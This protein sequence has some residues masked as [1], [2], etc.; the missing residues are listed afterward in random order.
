M[1]A[2]GVIETFNGHVQLRLGCPQRS[3]A[4]WRVSDIADAL[5]RFSKLIN[6]AI[7]TSPLGQPGWANEGGS[8]RQS[9][10]TSRTLR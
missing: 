6:V 10:R 2:N 4:T 1:V 7:A 8:P 9:I 3:I 5:I